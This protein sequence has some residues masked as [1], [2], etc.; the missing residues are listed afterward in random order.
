MESC[1]I[2]PQVAHN[3]IGTI[4]EHKFGLELKSNYII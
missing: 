2:F 1:N 3:N 4:K